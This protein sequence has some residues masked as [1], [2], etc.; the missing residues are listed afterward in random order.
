MTALLRD[1][2]R[3]DHLDAES[4]EQL[5]LICLQGLANLAQSDGQKARAARLLDAAALL[6]EELQSSGPDELST[7]EWEVAALITRGYSNRQIARELVISE[8]TVDSH[9]SHIMRKLAL[10]SR[11]QIAAWVV[12]RQPRLRILS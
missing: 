7:R 9:V 4:L 12:R 1:D 11:A 10:G 6:R 8:R 3:Q 2:A 5:V